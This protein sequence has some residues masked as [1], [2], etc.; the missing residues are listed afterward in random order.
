MVKVYNNKNKLYQKTI[1]YLDRILIDKYLIQNKY[2]NISI[3]KIEEKKD[4][5]MIVKVIEDYSTP[6]YFQKNELNIGFIPSSVSYQYYYMEIFKGEQGEI[7]LNN[8]RYNGM[9][10]S[11]LIPKQYIIT[12]PPTF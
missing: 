9:L 4:A 5:V 2:I 12:C 1:G 11:R 10:F 8:K 6:I 3:V 7:I